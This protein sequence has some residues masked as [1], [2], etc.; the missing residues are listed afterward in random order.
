MLHACDVIGMQYST[1]YCTA[2]HTSTDVELNYDDD[3]DCQVHLKKVFFSSL[4]HVLNFD[5]CLR[6]HDWAV[7]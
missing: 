2:H 1:K 4:S 3:D 5:N 7:V 6:V